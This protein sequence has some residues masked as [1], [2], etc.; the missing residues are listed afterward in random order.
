MPMDK[1]NLFNPPPPPPHFTSQ[2]HHE[3][4]ALTRLFSRSASIHHQQPLYILKEKR[5]FSGTPESGVGWPIPAHSSPPPFVKTDEDAWNLIYA[6][7]EQVARMKMK[8][9]MSTAAVAGGG[10][11]GAYYSPW[12]TTTD[13][14]ELFRQPQFCLNKG[15]NETCGN[16]VAAA[17]GH[18]GVRPPSFPRSARPSPQLQ[19]KPCNMKPA[20]AGGFDGG[21]G[22]ATAGKR[23]CAGTACS[24]ATLPAR[25]VQPSS[26]PPV[27]GG[28]TPHYGGQQ[29]RSGT[30]HGGVMVMESVVNNPEVLLPQEWTY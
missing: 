9:R 30:V 27:N 28:L 8:M 17:G 22:G 25:M 26:T 23:E 24:P 4:A 2:N 5:G 20:V 21:G 18:G 6:A 1:E 3:I 11:G 7:A 10:C 13:G 16:T 12:G 14:N 15:C 19:P 29:R